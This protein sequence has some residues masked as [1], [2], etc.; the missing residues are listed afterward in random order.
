MTNTYY[1]YP[2]GQ[3]VKVEQS[4]VA[5]R[6]DGSKVES[7]LF[8][9]GG[10]EAEQKTISDLTLRRSVDVEGLTQSVTTY[11]MS[12]AELRQARIRATRTCPGDAD[13]P[14]EILLGYSVVKTTLHQGDRRIESWMAP[15]L[16]CFILKQSVYGKS[17]DAPS[18]ITEAHSLVVGEPDPLL[19]SI[20]R[21]YRER[22]PSQV[23]AEFSRRY[24]KDAIPE[25]PDNLRYADRRYYKLN[26]REP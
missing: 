23:D 24:P 2:S 13:S 17:A 7:R 4:T 26:H 14:H 9:I 21:G 12:S 16:N 25:S 10:I 11:P 22:S 6:S 8:T 5:V 19:F 1:E 20:P 3:F 18:T 15:D